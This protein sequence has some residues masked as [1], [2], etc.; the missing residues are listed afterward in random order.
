MN[1]QEKTDLKP[2]EKILLFTF[3]SQLFVLPEYL[4]EVM[5]QNFGWGNIYPLRLYTVGLP[6]LYIFHKHFIKKSF[7]VPLIV[8]FL[9]LFGGF[10]VMESLPFREGP[11]SYSFIDMIPFRTLFFPDSGAVKESF[12]LTQFHNYFFFLMLVNFGLNRVTFYKVIDYALYAGI[13]TSIVTYLGFFGFIDTGGYYSFQELGFAGH[14][15]ALISINLIPYMGDFA[16]LMLIIKQ[17]NEKKF[18]LFYISRDVF[19]IFL[20]FTMIVIT[21]R[22]MPFIISLILIPYYCYIPWRFST[23]L[24]KGLLLFIIFIV[25]SMVI[26]TSFQYEFYPKVPF[27]QTFLYE[28][29]FVLEERETGNLLRKENIKNSLLN[30]EHHP[31]VGV[32]YHNASITKYR[33]YVIATRTGNEPLLILASCGIFY[34]LI[35]LYYNF[36]FMIFR[37]NLLRRPEVRLSFIFQLLMLLVIRPYSIALISISGYIAIYFYSVSKTNQISE[38]AIPTTIKKA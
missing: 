20:L 24:V 33:S 14:P 29:S 8:P 5:L 28:R 38:Q 3:V 31:F 25:I 32:G 36:R 35:Y 30:F 6:A 21:A 2:I 19:I 10:I 9:L 13:I 12:V 27:E 11:A 7:K 23:K 4:R 1:H 26:L 18:S 22:R 15:D 16:I 34:F 37:S 17:I